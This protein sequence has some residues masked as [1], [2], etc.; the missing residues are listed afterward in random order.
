LKILKKQ[1]LDMTRFF[2]NTTVSLLSTPLHLSSSGA[3]LSACQFLGVAN[4][5]LFA[6]HTELTKKEV[7]WMH[8][9]PAITSNFL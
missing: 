9:H 3:W 6:L 2:P 1:Q 7:K 4:F 8:E 5:C